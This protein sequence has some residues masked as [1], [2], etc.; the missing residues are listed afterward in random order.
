MLSVFNVS[1]FIV[2][3]CAIV[4]QDVTIIHAVLHLIVVFD[5]ILNNYLKL[6][7]VIDLENIDLAMAID[8]YGI[9]SKPCCKTILYLLCFF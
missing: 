9:V 7:S 8:A 5:S 2:R 3:V 1:H 6:K 4:R